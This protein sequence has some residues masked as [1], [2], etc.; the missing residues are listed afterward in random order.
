VF[1]YSALVICISCPTRRSEQGL[2]ITM[3]AFDNN[4]KSIFLS[5]GVKRFSLPDGRQTSASGPY[6][7]SIGPRD[8]FVIKPLL[9]AQNVCVACNMKYVSIV[10]SMKNKIIWSRSTVNKAGDPLAR[11]FETLLIWLRQ[12]RSRISFGLD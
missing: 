2:H 12:E 8:F 10:F 4:H 11:I 5:A 1:F 9:A 6:V 7:Q 3:P